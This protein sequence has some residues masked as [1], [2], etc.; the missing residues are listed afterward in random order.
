MIREL[1]FALRMLVKTPAFTLIAVLAVALGIGGSTTMFSAINALLL[2]PLPLI[3]DQDR[4]IYI[5]QFFAKAPEQD[6]GVA[7]PDYLEWKKQTTTLDLVSA[8]EE[9][10]IIV[11]GKDKPDRYLGAAISADTFEKLGVRPFIGRNFRAEED[12]LEAAPVALLGYDVW[13]KNFGGDEKV[14]GRVAPI[15]GKPTTIIGVMPQGWRFPEV[16]DIWVPLQMSEKEHPRGNFFLDVIGK[17]KP[18]VSVAQARAELEAITARIA[19]DHPETNAGGGVHVRP[20]REQMVKD[21]KTLTF[22]VMG[23]VLFVHLIACANVAN[24]LLARGATRSREVASRLAVGATRPQVVRQLLAESLLLGIGGSALGLIFAV[25]GVDLMVAAIP[26]ELPYWLRFDFDGRVFAFALAIGLISSVI[27]GLMPALTASRPRLTDVLKE[28]GGR[29]AGGTKGQRIRNGLVVAEVALALILLVGA[30]LM[31]RSFK[32]LQRVDIG[33]DPTSM[34]TFRIGLPESQFTDPELP[35]QFFEQLLPKLAVLPGVESVAA[36]TALPASG[37]IGLDALILE[38][39]AEPKQL[40]DARMARP[41]TVTP[42]FLQTAHIQLL[43]GHDFTAADH[44]DAPRVALIDEV[45]ARQWFPNQDPLGHKFRLI[46]KPKEEPKWAT[47]VGV[48]R[49]VIYDKIVRKR[50]Y[51]VVYF[52]H[53]QVRERF[54]SVAMRTRAEPKSFVNAARATVTSVNKDVPIYR[55]YT[56]EEVAAESVW[57]RKFFSNLFTTFAGLALFLASLGLYGVM[58]YSV[59]QRTQEIGVRMAL[60]AQAADVLRMIT[61]NGIR[62]IGLGLVIGFVGAHFLM[63]LLASSLHGVSAHDPLSFT[64]VPLIL[65]IV[66]LV[67]CYVPARHAMRLDPTEALRYE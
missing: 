61:G 18:G 53:A 49:P 56:G 59:R 30:G 60:G 46:S 12:N 3:Q 47:I 8:A 20:L 64:I 4:L 15:N 24:L 29:G 7:F 40:Q 54:M 44:K 67:A 33:A 31:M 25:W 26:N 11:S 50:V 19:A 1:R 43:R 23:A 13:Q 36:T 39:E 45:A 28:G 62:L 41:L 51:P 22:L 32:A 38:G 27:F 48:V 10:T 58:D 52:A 35:R 42:G 14:I 55:V 9:R 17:I 63:Q 66:G 57:D 37:N 2:R 65:L 21:V 5:N 34:L 6:A 16:S